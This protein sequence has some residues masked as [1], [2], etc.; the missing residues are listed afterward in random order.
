M[1]A[2]MGGV[3]ILA[4]SAWL[5][6]QLDGIGARVI[7]VSS[8]TMT[9][10]SAEGAA[11]AG[12]TVSLRGEPAIAGQPGPEIG[13]AVVVS[14]EP[15]SGGGDRLVIRPPVLEAGADISQVKS[16]AAAQGSGATLKGIVSGP[17]QSKRLFETLYLQAGGVGLVMV[18]GAIVMYW[19]VGTRQGSVEF[20]IATDGEMKKVNWSTKKNI[21]DSTTVVI[22]WSVL[23]AAG[24]FGVDFLFSQFFKLIGVLQH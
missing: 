17:A 4:M 2:T 22:L 11:A 3:L 23:L 15:T 10:S 9:L 1:T 24:L 7:P 12:Q 5:W 18:A 20:L 16:V 6:S 14:A 13:T 19:L 8:Y 21:V